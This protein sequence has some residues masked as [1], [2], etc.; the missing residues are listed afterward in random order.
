[1]AGN[2]TRGCAQGSQDVIALAIGSIDSVQYIAGAIIDSGDLDA[3]PFCR[4]L[5]LALDGV[6]KELQRPNQSQNEAQLKKVK[7]LLNNLERLC[8][9]RLS[10][11]SLVCL[12]ACR[13]VGLSRRAEFQI[14]PRIFVALYPLLLAGPFTMLGSLVE[15]GDAP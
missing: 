15:D 1:M 10:S 7:S 3:K 6:K 2:R 5:C 9:V 4:N 8:N 12:A 14:Q 13:D 11:S